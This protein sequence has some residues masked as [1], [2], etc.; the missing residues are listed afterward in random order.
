M[1][2]GEE[3]EGVELET[4]VE[5]ASDSVVV[6]LVLEISVVVVRTVVW[7][8]VFEVDIAIVLCELCPS[9]VPPDPSIESRTFG[10]SVLTPAFVKN[11]PMRVS[12][13]ALVPLH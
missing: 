2:T 1:G 9:L 13:Y 11:R 6:W 4:G 7:G 5:D 12:E 10:Q 8:R 3:A